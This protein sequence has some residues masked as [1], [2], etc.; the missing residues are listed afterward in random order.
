MQENKEG[1]SNLRA[2]HLFTRR[3]Q[4][5]TSPLVGVRGGFCASSFCSELN[6][7]SFSFLISSKFLNPFRSA[8]R[9]LFN[10]EVLLV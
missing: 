8:H 1:G 6:T 7:A 10:Y 2:V 4:V 9:C 5:L 3:L